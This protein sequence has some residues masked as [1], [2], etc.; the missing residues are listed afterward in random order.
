MP[1]PPNISMDVLRTCLGEQYGIA[2]IALDFLPRGYDYRAGV[3]RVVN[4]H[5]T[6]YLLKVTS[7]PLYEPS[8][9]VPHYLRDQGITA[10]VAPIPTISGS[11]W[12]RLTEQSGEWTVM[13]YPFLVGDTSLAGM[14]DDQWRETG[15][16]FKQIH[17]IWLPPGSVPSLRE[18]SFNPSGHI[19]WVRTFESQHLRQ[20]H[21]EQ[22]GSASARALRASWMAHQSTIHTAVTSLEQLAAAL[23]TRRL[24][25]VIAHADLHPA[26]L[27]R[28]SHGHVHVLDW[29]EV[30]LAPKE[31]DFIF[32][33][34]PQAHAFWE[35]YGLR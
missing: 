9:L 15:R 21:G 30:M 22:S 18:E 35:G 23:K 25:Y 7:R 5:G 34:E 20:A 3:Y 10:V 14:T 26:N 16:I 6:V 12:T 19:Q 32:I 17:Q 1:E 31:R 8:C 2:A 24:P 11:L 29:D 33:R 4:A 13:V 27:L 28:D